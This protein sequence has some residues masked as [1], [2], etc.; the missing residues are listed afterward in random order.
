MKLSVNSAV[1][2]RGGGLMSTWVLSSHNI[3]ED[4]YSDELGLCLPSLLFT[5]HRAEYL[6]DLLKIF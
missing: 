4:V 3:V 2:S 5:G 1:A 6:R